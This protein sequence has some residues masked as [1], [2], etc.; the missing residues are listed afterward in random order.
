MLL[1]TG[2]CAAGTGVE[3]D[4][5]VETGGGVTGAE[6]SS[7]LLFA[8]FLSGCVVLLPKRE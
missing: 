4:E 5:G 1:K 7:S 3:I 6:I 8:P 2:G